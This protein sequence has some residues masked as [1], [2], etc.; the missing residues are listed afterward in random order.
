MGRHDHAIRTL[1]CIYFVG[2]AAALIAFWLVL[3]R[4]PASR[5]AF[6]APG[7][8]HVTLTAFAWG[9]LLLYMP[10]S[11]LAAWAL[12][13][14]S[15]F[16]VPVLFLHAG[17]AMYAALYAIGFALMQQDRWLGAAMMAPALVVPPML[18]FWAVRTKERAP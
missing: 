15:R 2:Q 10:T 11:L 9:D 18:A 12:A 13:R 16:L 3:W 4:S 8:P 14:R 5:E 1:G 7:A 17:A 6:L